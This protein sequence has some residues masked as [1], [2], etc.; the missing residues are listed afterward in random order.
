MRNTI[1]RSI[2]VALVF[3]C[4][5]VIGCR[6]ASPPVAFYSLTSLDAENMKDNDQAASKNM[7]IGIGPVNFPEVLDRPQIVTR[8][9]PS[10]IE[11]SE[12]NRWGGDLRLDFLDVLAQNISI[13]TGSDQ[14]FKYPV[15]GNL[16][17][18][19]HVVLDVHQFDGR[20]GESVVLRVS[21]AL[22]KNQATP[23][24]Q[25]LIK[26]VI[27]QPVSGNGYEALVNAQSEAINILSREIASA[28]KKDS[29]PQ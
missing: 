26:T 17:P 22:K 9:S 21:W 25:I 6:S 20:L 14:I 15:S 5:S 29:D 7:S 13:I 28:I 3:V 10:R 12:F 16:E 18:A 24:Q 11:F 2:P 4:I 23:A 1:K 19:Y 27:N 8:L